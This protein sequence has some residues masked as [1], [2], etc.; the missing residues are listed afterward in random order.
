MTVL[1]TGS[2]YNQPQR[3]V[4][5]KPFKEHTSRLFFNSHQTKIELAALPVDDGGWVVLKAFAAGDRASLKGFCVVGEG[6]QH[7]RCRL[8]ILTLV[9]S[10]V[11]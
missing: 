10:V 3:F 1:F 11:C 5:K 2:S 4:C 9:K 8:W 6:S 7:L